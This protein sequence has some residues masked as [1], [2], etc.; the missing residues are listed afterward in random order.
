LYWPPE[1][2]DRLGLTGLRDYMG[3]HP[4]VVQAL[5]A[6]LAQRLADAFG[7]HAV[8]LQVQPHIGRAADRIARVA[9]DE[10]VDLIVV[11]SHRRGLLERAMVG[12]VSGGV[13]HCAQMSVVCVPAPEHPALTRPGR[14]TNVLVATDFTDTGNDALAL[15]YSLVAPG[16]CVHLAHVVP[17]EPHGPV[18]ARDIFAS[19]DAIARSDV[20]AAARRRLKELVLPGFAGHVAS[21]VHVLESNSPAEAIAQAAERLDS[22]LICLGTH[23]RGGVS[24]ALLGSVAQAVLHHTQRP[25]LF[26][27]KPK[28]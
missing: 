23:G 12:S 10:A 16:G 28:A 7:S 6:Q 22:E 24:K 27:R 19:D 17:P 2:F 26:S 5:Q 13:L 4:E 21:Q 1:Q 11:G 9:A 14:M 15:A 20:H 8:R 18:E 3:P 25:V